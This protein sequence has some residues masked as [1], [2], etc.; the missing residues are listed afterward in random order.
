MVA[1]V[2]Y[3]VLFAVALTGGV[4]IGYALVGKTLPDRVAGNMVLI[5]SLVAGSLSAYFHSRFLN[6][7]AEK[8]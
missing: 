4:R 3:G 5:T 2:G 1:A 6:A 7:D 8:Q